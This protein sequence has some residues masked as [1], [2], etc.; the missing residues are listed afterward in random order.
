MMGRTLQVL[1]LM[2]HIT[3]SQLS[4][5]FVHFYCV[6]RQTGLQLAVHLP[7]PPS[8]KRMGCTTTPRSDP[9]LFL[10]FALYVWPGIVSFLEQGK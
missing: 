7:Q 1:F 2:A 9:K 8:A 10:L 3:A 5:L 4:L 6:L